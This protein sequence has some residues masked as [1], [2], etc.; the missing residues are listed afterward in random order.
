M[1]SLF[2]DRKPDEY[3][4]PGAL[5]DILALIKAYPQAAAVGGNTGRVNS[6]VPVDMAKLT[7]G[8]VRMILS[9]RL[10]GCC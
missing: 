2:S 4:A 8:A 5:A 1:F 6:F 9:T 7:G 3:D 10:F